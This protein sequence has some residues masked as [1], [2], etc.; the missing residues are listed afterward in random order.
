M[1][2]RIWNNKLYM[3]LITGLEYTK[4][5]PESQVNWVIFLYGGGEWCFLGTLLRFG[6]QARALT[7]LF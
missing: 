5:W 2:F 1:V 3:W 6:G 7:F 4:K